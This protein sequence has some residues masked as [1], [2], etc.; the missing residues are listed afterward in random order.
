MTDKTTRL[1]LTSPH[2]YPTYGGAQ[3]RYRG[4][5]TGFLQRGLDVHVLTGTPQL[6]ERGEL[7]SELSWYDASPGSW[8]TPSTLDEAPLERIRLPDRKGR[9]RSR[10]YYEAMLDM[11]RREHEGPVVVQLLTNMRPS[12]LPWLKKLKQSGAAIVYSVSQFPKWQRK[13]LKRLFRSQGYERVYNEFDAL[14]TNSEEI[15]NFLRDMGVKTHIEYIPNG[16]D[17][18]RFHPAR[19]EA[20]KQQA[21]AIRARHDIPLEH[22]VIVSVG[23]VMPRKRPDTIIEAWSKL[24]EQYP[25]THLLFVGPRADQYDP[26][27]KDFGRH[28]ASLVEQSGDSSKIHFAGN[29]GDVESHLRASDIFILASEREGTPNSVLE[30]MACGL[31]C[32]VTPFTGISGSI[33][34]ADQHYQLVD[35][36]PEAICAKLASLLHDSDLCGSLQASGLSLATNNFDRN[37]TL[38]EYARLYEKLAS[39]ANDRQRRNKPE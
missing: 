18:Q 24:R 19:S 34:A 29:V 20:E 7:D 38:D 10:I 16:V 8:L 31:P 11:C 2:F 3:N 15:K 35:R 30:A 9:A 17:L 32:L 36:N 39:I 6:E 22:K 26:K 1:W 37:K 23:A 25:D 14:V 13:P 27:L 12:A 28:I 33:G 4:Y 5:I 21:L